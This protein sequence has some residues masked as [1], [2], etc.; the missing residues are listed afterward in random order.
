MY[1]SPPCSLPWVGES[2]RSL[3]HCRTSVSE[4]ML[5]AV[6]ADHRHRWKSVITDDNNNTA[7]LIIAWLLGVRRGR[8]R[9]RATQ[10]S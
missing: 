4:T 1:T 6:A 7:W 8:G 9:K 3:T 10:T 2:D 5:A